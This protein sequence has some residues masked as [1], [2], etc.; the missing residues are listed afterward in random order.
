MGSSIS[1]AALIRELFG[2]ELP[3][4][5]TRTDWMR[6]P[7]TSDQLRYAAEDV[8]QL[9]EAAT[10][11]ER[12]LRELGR[13]DWALEDAASLVDNDREAIE[14]AAAWRRV[15]GIDRLPPG[16][17]GVARALA[18]W[19][20]GEAERLDLAR[21]FLLRDE[22]LLALARRGAAELPSPSEITK[23]PGYDARRHAR[24]AGSWAGALARAHA[25]VAEGIAPPEPEPRRL[26]S[27]ERE[28]RAKIED[29]VTELVARRAGELGLPPELLLSRRQRER[30]LSALEDRESLAGAIGGF[31]SRLFGEELERLATSSS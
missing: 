18:A 11:L 25:E 5:E 21:S 28:R 29:A 3:K 17:R 20:D 16:A 9:V 8:A 26:S 13:L 12:R 7:L 10:E 27:S 19:R 24:H 6:R 15:K 23:L 2:V 4:D 31:R 14:P 22:T 1:Y 30:A